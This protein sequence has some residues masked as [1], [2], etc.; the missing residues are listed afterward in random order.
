MRKVNRGE[1]EPTSRCLPREVR[2]NHAMV[3]DRMLPL[4]GTLEGVARIR[5]DRPCRLQ[6]LR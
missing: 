2:P 1:Y 4:K 6:T 5:V 3:K